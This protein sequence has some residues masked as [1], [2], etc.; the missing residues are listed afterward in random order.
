MAGMSN[1]I[2][3]LLPL[4]KGWRPSQYVTG[5]PNPEAVPPET[6]HL[7]FALLSRP[8]NADIQLDLFLNYETNVALYPA[9]QQYFRDR[10]P[11]VLAVWGKNDQ[12]FVAAGAEAYKKDNPNAIVRLI[13]GGHFAL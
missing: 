5:E 6:Y 9:F 10:K 13:D 2:S 12:L 3:S 11:P 7:D 1:P 8:G 4:S